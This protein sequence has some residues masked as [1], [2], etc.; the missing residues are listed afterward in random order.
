VLP[1]VT[2]SGRHRFDMFA[3]IEFS[4]SVNQ[5]LLETPS[6]FDFYINIAAEPSSF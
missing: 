6:I 5:N 1:H 4:S 2:C 3:G